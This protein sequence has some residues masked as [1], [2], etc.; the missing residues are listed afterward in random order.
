M[1]D[2][3]EEVPRL[4]EEMLGDD[5]QPNSAPFREN[6][7]DQLTEANGTL[8]EKDNFSEFPGTSLKDGSKPSLVEKNVSLGDKVTTVKHR[9][10]IMLLKAKDCNELRETKIPLKSFSKDESLKIAEGSPGT[11]VYVGLMEDGREVAVKRI[12][13]E[14]TDRLAQNELEIFRLTKD[15]RS[16]YIVNYW[17]FD[18]DDF[19]MYLVIDLCEE[20]LKKYVIETCSLEYLRKHGVRMIEE[21]LLGLQVLHDKGILHRDL[22]PSNIL[23][24]VDGRMQLSDFGISRVPNDD[25]STFLTAPKGT[26][27]WMPP[28]V[29]EKIVNEGSKGRYKRKSDVHVAGMIAF[30]ILTK[31]EHPFGPQLERMSN[32]LKGEPIFLDKVTALTARQFISE[33]ISHNVEHRPYVKDALKHCFFKE[34]SQSIVHDN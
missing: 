11:R 20:N 27:G 26:V 15:I 4:E 25:K 30:F 3:D 33:L 13:K 17:Y 28:E 8:M 14:T 16:P 1:R 12:L 6:T 32:I 23:V 34:Q 10:K 21:I 29:I 7:A 18:A 24:S 9:E 5:I 2:L 19:Y 31:G 22:K